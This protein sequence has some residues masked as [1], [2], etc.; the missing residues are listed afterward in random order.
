MR[1]VLR[2]LLPVLIWTLTAAGKEIAPNYVD[3]SQWARARKLEARPNYGT[4]T[5]ALTNEWTRLIFHL[6]STQLEY[7]DVDVRLS[8]PVRRQGTQ[9]Q[10]ASRDLETVLGPLLSPPKRS[11][12]RPIRIIALG[13]GHGGNDPGNI[14]GPKKEK[15]YTLALARA[16]R[17][18]LQQAGFKV[19][20]LREEDSR[21]ELEERAEK[22]NLARADLF[23]S[24]HFNGYPGRS[25]GSVSGVE[26]YCL[27]PAGTSSSN[28][29]ERHGGPW[30]RG[31]K[32]DRENINLAYQIHRSLVEQVDLP[33]RGVRRARFKELTLLDMPGVLVEGGYLTNEK[34]VSLI[35][36]AA[37][38]NRY[39]RAIADGILAY[40]RLVERGQAE[41]A[42]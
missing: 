39:A 38:R 34:D 24:L 33:D 30:L 20:M 9:W 16:L 5:L 25:P 36:S 26:T 29:N 8:H 40:K 32:T 23:V 2:A 37:G 12:G 10:I 41:E 17:P 11:A 14:A 15:T 19:V 35:D 1:L 27:T 28:D 31:N 13:A 18:L 22:A 6:D 4:K 3:L 21:V 42:K 7:E